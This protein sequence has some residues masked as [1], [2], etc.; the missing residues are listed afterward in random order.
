VFGKNLNL[1]EDLWS[2][3]TSLFLGGAIG[4]FLG[5]FLAGLSVIPLDLSIYSLFLRAEFGNAWVVGSLVLNSLGDGIFAVF[6][7][8]SAILLSAYRRR[9]VAVSLGESSPA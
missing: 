9:Q 7:G 6:A 4:E 2:P 8:I 3:V 1:N 5:I